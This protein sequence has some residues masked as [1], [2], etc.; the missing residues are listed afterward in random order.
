MVT[1]PTNRTVA[2]RVRTAMELAGQ[3]PKALADA[4]GLPR[5]TLNRR[6]TGNSDFTLH[7]LSVLAPVLGLTIGDLLA[8][9]PSVA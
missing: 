5:T 3:T 2:Q 7:E 1:P 4:T 8:D 6:L 9:E